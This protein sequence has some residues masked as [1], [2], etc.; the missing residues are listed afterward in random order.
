[1]GEEGRRRELLAGRLDYITVHVPT[2]TISLYRDW[3]RQ[4]LIQRQELPLKGEVAPF[5]IQKPCVRDLSRGP[6]ACA[7]ALRMP[8]PCHLP[9]LLVI[10]P[11]VQPALGVWAWG[12]P[13]VRVV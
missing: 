8:L 1:M 3:C 6:P 2:D 4:V 9:V 10:S 11:G 13:R 5:P 7:T 12:L